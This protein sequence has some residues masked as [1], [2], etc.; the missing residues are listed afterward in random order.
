MT[1][2]SPTTTTSRRCPAGTDRLLIFHIAREGVMNSL[3]HAHASDMWISVREQDESI[4][5]ELRDNGVGFDPEAR[6][7]KVT[8][9]WR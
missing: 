6:G 4:V 8:S 5:L 2:E 3:K 7:R 1:R 9:A